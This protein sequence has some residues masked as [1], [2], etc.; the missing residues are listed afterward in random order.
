M[1]IKGYSAVPG[2]K[3]T[4]LN[5]VDYIE[6]P[7]AG[8]IY[9]HKEHAAKFVVNEINKKLSKL[10]VHKDAIQSIGNA[11][12]YRNPPQKE[13]SEVKPKEFTFNKA[14]SLGI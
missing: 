3:Y 8:H 2:G 4:K 12:G 7:D 5:T 1:S 13:S 6:I 14:F 11:F 9:Q 10:Y